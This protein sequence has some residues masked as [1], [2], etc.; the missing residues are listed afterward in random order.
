MDGK[1]EKLVLLQQI[2]QGSRGAFNLFYEQYIHFVFHIAVSIL[3]NQM[4]A[5]DICHDIFIE[6]F[7]KPDEYRPENGSIKAWLAVKTKSRCLDWQ[8]KKKPVLKEKLEELLNNQHA[9]AKITEL[10]VL[11]KIE[12]EAVDEALTKIPKEQRDVLYRSYFEG[13]TQK[14]L[15]QDMNRPLG[16]IKSY[17]R[18]GLNNLRKQKTLLHWAKADGGG[19]KS[20]R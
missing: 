17:V 2:Q 9:G 15:A 14:E 8:R 11:S 10:D 20:E 4:E 1:E 7:Q 3:K 5:E 13:R 12:R 18:Y 6:V 16:T 19:K